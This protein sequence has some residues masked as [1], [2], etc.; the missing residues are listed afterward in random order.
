MERT[1]VLRKKNSEICIYKKITVG[2]NTFIG[3]RSI[4]MPGVNIGSNC[5]IGAGCIVTKDVPNNMVVA[6]VPARIVCTIDEYIEK[7]K[8]NFSYI[9]NKPYLEK[10]EILLDDRKK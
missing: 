6:G 1:H 2:D 9:L 4:I 5:I 7:N 3:A 10:K 8:S